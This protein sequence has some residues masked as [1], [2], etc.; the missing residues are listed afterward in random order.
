MCGLDVD[1][2]WIGCGLDVVRMW[3][4]SGCGLDPEVD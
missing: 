1:W 4:G 2:M 3:I